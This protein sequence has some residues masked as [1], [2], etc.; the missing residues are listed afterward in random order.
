MAFVI[1]D[2]L[3]IVCTKCPAVATVHHQELLRVEDAVL[4]W[5]ECHGEHWLALIDPFVIRHVVENDADIVTSALRRLEKPFLQSLLEEAENRMLD[6]QKRAQ[7]LQRFLKD[8][9]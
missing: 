7:L 9:G 8:A 1:P 2:P 6:S 4:V 5:V 3:R